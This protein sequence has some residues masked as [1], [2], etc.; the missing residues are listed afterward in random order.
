[1]KKITK[2]SILQKITISILSIMLLFNFIVPTYSH[3]DFGGVLLSPVVDLLCS[4]G[5]A[6]VNLLQLCM[7]GEAGSK[8]VNFSM[9][10]FLVE[11]D[12]FWANADGK[13]D[14]YIGAGGETTEN[15]N[16]EEDFEKGWF[17]ISDKYHIPI[18]TYSPE[19]IFAGKVAGLDINFIN[20]NKY[21]KSDGEEVESSAAKLQPTIASWYVAIRNLAV[22][23]LLSILVYVGIRIIISSTASDK[24]KYKQMLVDWLIALCILF[25]MHYLMSFI[26]TMTESVCTAI[27][28]DGSSNITVNV[29][30]EN[31]SHTFNTNLLGLAR[32]K[33]QYKDF[34][35]KMAY[36][37]MYLAL[38]I[39]TVVFTWFY[40]KRLLMM[41]FLTLIAPA[42]ALTYPIDKMNDGKAQAFDAWLK[43]YAFNALIQPFHLIIYYVFVTSAMDLASTNIIY[44][45]AA[46][47]FIMPAEKILRKFFGFD[48]A[49][50]GTL[51]ALAGGLTAGSLMSK[52]GKGKSRGG[53][54]GKASGGN[55]VE[56][57]EKPVRFEKKHDVGQI[58][59]GNANSEGA[60]TNADESE[61]EDYTQD[62]LDKY[63]ADGYGQN[64]NGE[65]FN[66]WT[67]EYDANYD[68]TKDAAYMPQ[69]QDN[70][71]DNSTDGQ[72][73]SIENDDK[74]DNKEKNPNMFQNWT[75]AHGIT[76]GSVAKGAGRSITGAAKFATRTAFKAGAGT[77]AG[78]VTLASG[79][80]FAGASAAFV[81]GSNLGGR[82]GDKVVNAGSYVGRGV[83][84]VG[85]AFYA[86]VT[87]ANGKE[88][89]KAAEN[90]L[91]GGTKLGKELDLAHGNTRYQDAASA[92]QFKT[93]KNNLQ[94]LRDQMAAQNGGV[95][96]TSKEVKDK[97]N[98][99]D[100]YLSE[101]MKDI[102]E[103]LKA[104]KAEQ[105]GISS[106]QA[107]I[108]AAIGKEKGITADVLNDDKK[109]KAQQANLRQEFINKGQSAEVATRQADY[110]INVLKAQNG[111][112]N[113][114]K[115]VKK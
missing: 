1:M 9:S 2:K 102:K 76:L 17:G 3:A 55:N 75:R 98:S 25:F 60:T 83:G 101:G 50:A 81:A 54:S 74:D 26:I 104:Q 24:A 40:L 69:Q 77:L 62:A 15:I 8:D 52:L 99:F 92:K 19:Q 89:L 108:I 85:K 110:T 111:V 49:G 70:Q 41:A 32:F 28:G 113:N 106:K 72:A 87:A 56:S 7:T 105:Y 96:P 21:T 58:E 67:D 107:A 14:K 93:D 38:V 68:P 5:D 13:Y 44:M 16:V 39:Y 53:S 22:V 88:G 94:Y 79:G 29:T 90:A 10:A 33:T 47:A 12:E 100:P 91:L 37:I 51:G 114:L 48:K 36:L 80:G 59:G 97:M 6:V 65:Y 115:K 82:L 20:P 103:M 42:V 73:N 11:D 45:I 64:A 27:A 61:S 23:G 35:P 18:A 30:D 4:I 109:A 46:L 71:E 43:E 78:A 84:R 34:G 112:A 31:G 86:D 57:G 95:A 66:P 63:S